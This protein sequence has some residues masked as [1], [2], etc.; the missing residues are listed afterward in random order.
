M[1]S[2]SDA[3]VCA[4]RLQLLADPTRLAVVRRLLSGPRTVGEMQRALGV[5]QS[6]LSHHLRVLRDAGLVA[7]DRQGRAVRYRLAAGVGVRTAGGALDL[8]CCSLSWDQPETGGA[9]R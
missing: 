1:A 7:G 4:E 2:S 3:S 8:G 9:G 5:E 6:L